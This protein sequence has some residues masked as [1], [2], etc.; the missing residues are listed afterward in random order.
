MCVLSKIRHIIVEEHNKAEHEEDDGKGKEGGA[1]VH[2]I[3]RPVL[4]P[5]WRSEPPQ[6]L[7]VFE[8][9]S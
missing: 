2:R 4:S 6:V 8:I 1:Y 7:G 5:S 9:Q 3:D